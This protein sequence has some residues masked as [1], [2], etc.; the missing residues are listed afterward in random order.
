M[1]LN[2]LSSIYLPAVEETLQEIINRVNQPDAEELRFMLAYHMG[3]EG[4]GAGVEARGKRIRPLL[5]LLVTEAAGGDWREALPGAAAVEL[6]HNFSLIHDDIEDNSTLRHNRKTVWMLWGIPQAINTGDAMYTLAH[7]ALLGLERTCSPMNVL[8]ATRLLQEACLRLTEGQHL[9]ISYELRGDLTL[10]SYWPMVKGKT[11]ALL[12]AST[13]IG[14]IV[15]GAP[16]TTCEAYTRFALALGLAFQAQDDLL[17]IWGDS[18]TTGKSVESDLVSGKK[19]LPVLYGLSKNGPFAERWD[20]G[21]I[22]A[23]EVISIAGMLAQE[24]AYE[25]TQEKANQYTDEAIRALDEAKPQGS[26]GEALRELTLQLLN[27][28]A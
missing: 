10:E 16:S 2:K 25:Y 19:T 8:R 12:E 13:G 15:A 3:W 24:G 14:A 1:T 28:N 7:L 6:I 26:A 9:D 27:R 21:H 11:A 18:K 20:Q 22:H 17:G 4:K 23:E 5:L